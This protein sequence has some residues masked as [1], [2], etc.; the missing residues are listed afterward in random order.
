MSTPGWVNLKCHG[1]GGE[2]FTQAVTMVWKRGGGATP[3]P[4][5][6]RCIGCGMAVDV[7]RMTAR[8][9]LEAAKRIVEDLEEAGH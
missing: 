6:M 5:G 7:A 1:C 3:S 2:L 4:A 9:E 8:L